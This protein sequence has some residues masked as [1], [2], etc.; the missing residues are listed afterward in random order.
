MQ[1][2]TPP[3]HQL[4]WWGCSRP[5]LQ[6]EILWERRDTEPLCSGVGLQVPARRGVGVLPASLS[7]PVVP[8]SPNPAQQRHEQ[9][10]REGGKAG[11]PK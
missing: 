10:E 9:P 2:E 6:P 1:E 5:S 3:E 11:Q 8:Q 7:L 4:L